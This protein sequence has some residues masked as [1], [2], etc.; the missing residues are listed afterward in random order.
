[1]R[2][3]KWLAAGRAVALA[4]LLLA[5]PAACLPGQID[6]GEAVQIAREF[7]VAGQPSAL[8]FLE[9]TNEAPQPSGGN[10]RVY[11]DARVRDSSG[12]SIWYHFIIDVD[13]STG[14]PT[15]YAQG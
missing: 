2:R 7:V 14:V 13:R 11:V 10:W 3:S 4:S 8:E 6:E 1:M 9:L 15:I 12:E 5:L